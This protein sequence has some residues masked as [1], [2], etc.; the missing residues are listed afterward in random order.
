M[1]PNTPAASTTTTS[2]TILYI[3]PTPNVAAAASPCLRDSVVQNLS[4]NPEPQTHNPTTSTESTT[5]T[6]STTST[7]EADNSEFKIQNSELCSPSPFTNLDS[8]CALAD[9]QL[10]QLRAGVPA[11]DIPHLTAAAF[12][13]Y[14]LGHYFRLQF[15]PMHW[16]SLLRYDNLHHAPPTFAPFAPSHLCV[17]NSPEHPHQPAP[18]AHSHHSAFRIQNS[19]LF[20]RTGTRLALAAPRGNA[21]STLHSLLFP[22][23]D[24][25]FQRERYILL[26]SSTARQ[27][28]GRLSALRRALDTPGLAEAFGQI[29]KGQPWNRRTLTIEFP[30]N[31]PT[32]AHANTLA[33]ANDAQSPLSPCSPFGPLNNPSQA[34]QSTV[35]PAAPTTANSPRFHSEFKI[36]NSEFADA[37]AAARAIRVDAYGSA[38]ELRGITHDECRPTKIILDDAESS[39]GS[40][41]QYRRRQLLEWFHEVV[42]HLGSTYTHIEVIGTILHRD[43]LLCT[44]MR[45]PDFR[46]R[47]Y[48]AVNHWATNQE[49]WRKWETMFTNLDDPDREHTAH[50]FYLTN[51]TEMDKGT[52]VLW[53]EHENYHKLMQQHLTIGRNAF[54]KEKQ[55]SPLNFDERIFDSN[56]WVRFTTHEGTLIPE[57]DKPLLHL[58]HEPWMG[59]VDT[60]GS[61]PQDASA[62]S[63]F[64]SSASL[65]HC[66]KNNG[67]TIP[68][69]TVPRVTLD[70]LHIFG[71][72]DPATALRPGSRRRDQSAIVTLG[73]SSSGYLYM[74]DVWQGREDF[75]SLAKRIFNLNAQYKY[76]TFGYESNGFQEVFQD[77]LTDEAKNL[78]SLR[79]S[80]WQLNIKPVRNTINK[81]MRIR[82]LEPLANTGWLSFSRRLNPEFIVQADEY[83]AEH[84]DMLDALA[85]CVELARACAPVEIPATRQ[86]LT[87]PSIA[88]TKTF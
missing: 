86:I 20:S 29:K 47:V 22:L 67:R 46:S 34:A 35:H 41:R 23:L 61:I 66:G 11:R 15:S 64:A 53:P 80:H 18:A 8:Y 79:S 54:F 17:K 62:D 84:D 2:A 37:R 14:F 57:R 19:E 82:A 21:K 25:L 63:S 13:R 50:Q 68:E 45:R 88:G 33:P 9:V 40:L 85:A 74:L 71:F 16:D 73:R 51:K 28:Q 49:L 12:A 30:N 32:A 87:R 36:Q 65:P 76:R 60:S 70:D 78:R 27:A 3:T 56:T 52:S 69:K 55:N 4:P 81:D 75:A 72:L 24:I 6:Q 31:P 48:R 59:P 7:T 77:F 83:P 10:D 5:S 39:T 42:E 38:A 58:G 43:S 1:Q 26:L 44:A